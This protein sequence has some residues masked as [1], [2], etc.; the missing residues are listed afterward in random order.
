MIANE[1]LRI[2]HKSNRMVCQIT[3]KYLQKLNIEKLNIE[4]ISLTLQQGRV[5]ESGLQKENEI[6]K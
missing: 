2:A 4:V 6:I 1:M 5:Q 3:R